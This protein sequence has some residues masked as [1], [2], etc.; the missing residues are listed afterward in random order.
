MFVRSRLRNWG[1]FTEILCISL[2]GKW[3][4][5]THLQSA[6]LLNMLQ[7]CLIIALTCDTAL[8]EKVQR[9]A[10]NICTGAMKRTETVK[11]LQ[12]LG[13][14][15]LKSRRTKAKLILLYKI[16]N[17]LVSSSYLLNSIPNEEVVV[18]QYNFRSIVPSIPNVYSRLKT[19][20]SS[21]FP[22]YNKALE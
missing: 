22:G 21:F 16:K 5:I 11:V 13:W 10:A 17:S 15:T 4:G 12:E 9:R 2:F 18:R 1:C 8:L 6:R 14:E 20:E 3:P 19:R 7:L